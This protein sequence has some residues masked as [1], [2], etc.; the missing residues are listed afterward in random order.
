MAVLCNARNRKIHT[1]KLLNRNPAFSA[2]KFSIAVLAGSQIGNLKQ[3]TMKKS[4]LF[5]EIVNSRSVLVLLLICINSALFGQNRQITGKVVANENDSL[6][7]GVTVRVK[8]TT[9]SAT[10]SRDGNFSIG[11]PANAVLVFSSIGFTPQEVVVGNQN[12]INVR[13]ATDPQS[14]QQVVVVGYGTVKRKDVTGAI[15]S[16]SS[17]QIQKV[18]VTTLDQAM[19]GHAAGVQVVNNDA[20]P[21]GNVSVLIR[22]IGSLASG[23]NTPLYVIDGYPT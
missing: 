9:T 15:S 16:I 18:P 10:T 1:K 2:K 17:E 13:L 20:S 7:E 12:S 19:Q 3:N 5:Y 11:V 22:G 4:S 8:G 21:G 14:L 6:L 23:G